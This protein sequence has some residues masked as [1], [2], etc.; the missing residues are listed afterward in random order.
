MR[1]GLALLLLLSV[2]GFAP[3][4][5]SPTT[6]VVKWD[7]ARTSAPESVDELK[8]LQDT[9]KKMVERTTPSTV[10]L[11]YE[12]GAGSGAIISDDGIILTAAH[13]VSRQQVSLGGP[14][15]RNQPA[16]GEEL[17][18][19]SK[20]VSIM[21]ADGTRV[22]GTVLGRNKR[23]D[24]AM[25]KITS[26]IPKN[27][28][29][30]GA[31]KGKWPAVELGKSSDLKKGQ[32]VVSL[33]HPGGP[34]TDRRAPARL[35]QMVT[36]SEKGNRVSSDCTLV[37]G[38][39]GGPL[40][41]LDGKLIGIHSRIGWTLAQNIHVPID[42]FKTDWDQLVAGTEVGKAKAAAAPPVYFGASFTDNDGN[43]VTGTKGARVT[44]V[45]ED[46]PAA[47]GGIRVNDEI[48][49][50]GGTAVKTAED[51]RKLLARRRVGDDVEVVVARG[52]RTETL[53]VTLTRR[54]R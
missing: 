41:D 27:A 49:S 20:N 25:V 14:R 43:D 38:D 3:A 32:W 16:A 47:E 17:P 21:L 18:P 31:D 15:R 54:P 52:G 40:F 46:S 44:L 39:S 48:T 2:A 37:G 10:A 13:V 42:G 8:A 34:K 35:G 36:V 19:E 23:A 33:G 7:I 45:I 6:T 22:K 51:V 29:W 5:D 50:F 30:D 1:R 26:E 4:V 28:K 24:S 11:F 9:V 53:T 12:G